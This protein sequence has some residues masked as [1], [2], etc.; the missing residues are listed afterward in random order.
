M[1][2][3]NVKIDKK[4]EFTQTES[5]QIKA[6]D[7][8][9]EIINKDIIQNVLKIDLDYIESYIQF[10]DNSYSKQD[11]SLEKIEN[12]EK[13]HNISNNN[14]VNIKEENKKVKLNISIAHIKSIYIL[15][16]IFNLLPKRKLLQISKYSKNIQEKLNLNFDDYKD[17]CEIEI[18]IKPK[19]N[20]FDKFI[21]I[22][23]NKDKSYYHIYFN[24]NKEEI[25]RTFIIKNERVSNIK[26]IIDYQVDSFYQLFYDC[27]Y[28]E[29]INFKKFNRTNIKDMGYMFYNCSSLEILNLS[30]FNTNKVTSMSH[31]FFECTSLK[32]INL[33]K[34]NTENVESMCAMF[35]SC[36]SL[37][38]LNLS[39]FITNNVSDMSLMFYRC[40]SLKELNISNFNT[41]K[42]K[43]MSY[44]FE[45]CSSLKEINLSNFNTEKITYMTRIFSECSS[46]IK[47]NISN[48]N[49][50]NVI[51]MNEMFSGCLSLK[52]INLSNFNTEKVTKMIKMFSNCSSLEDIN[53]SNFNTDNVSDMSG[54]FFGCSKELIRKIQ[55][56]YKN[57]RNEAFE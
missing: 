5:Q 21:N 56:K 49:T 29:S 50:N 43:S 45:K 41:H 31:M 53:L 20:Q 40:S 11:N 2:C 39:N 55:D 14:I 1:G 23:D 54:M 22:I 36:P 6:K 16:R 32:T 18:E 42:L 57:I 28:I 24:N 51:E 33:S 30:N 34:F 19:L 35:F 7:K 4:D 10:I 48:F 27:K 17:F 26:V 38:K 44:M 13:S 52:K 12:E 15:K 47:V 25:K 3:C 46:L 8:F 37:E 9:E